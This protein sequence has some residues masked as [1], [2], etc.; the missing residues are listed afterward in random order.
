MRRVF[1]AVMAAVTGC[2]PQQHNLPAESPSARGADTD[3]RGDGRSNDFILRALAAAKVGYVTQSHTNGLTSHFGF[4]KCEQCA[5]T[6]GRSLDGNH[7]MVIIT[8]GAASPVRVYRPGRSISFRFNL[9]T[10]EIVDVVA[11]EAPVEAPSP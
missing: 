11:A 8:D 5:V 7:V 4:G 1:I 2:A 10:G 9:N 3:I 6:S